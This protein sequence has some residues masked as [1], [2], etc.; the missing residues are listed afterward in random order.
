MADGLWLGP[1]CSWREFHHRRASLHRH[2]SHASRILRRDA[3]QRS[4]RNLDSTAAGGADKSRKRSAELAVLSL[5]SRHWTSAPGGFDRS[6]GPASY[7]NAAPMDV[8]RLAV[9]G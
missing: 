7:C 5:A 1:I 6:H 3:T 8:E 9:S 2:W 4:T